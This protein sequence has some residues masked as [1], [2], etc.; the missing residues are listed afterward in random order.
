MTHPDCRRKHQP[1]VRLIVRQRPWPLQHRVRKPHRRRRPRI[2]LDPRPQ[3]QRA[4][5][6]PRADNDAC[7]GISRRPPQRGF[8]ARRAI[9]NKNASGKTPHP[10]IERRRATAASKARPVA[11]SA[12]APPA[13]LQPATDQWRC[14]AM[15]E[16]RPSASIDRDRQRPFGAFDAVTNKPENVA[17]RY[18]FSR[19]VRR[20]CTKATP[21]AE[22]RTAALRPR[23]P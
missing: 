7:A 15:C 11:S 13:A 14:C 20:C 17:A 22:L 19:A 6:K 2:D 3:L 21:P 9:S 4:P 8:L 23:G 1:V 10:Y 5:V 16:S 12:T 18:S